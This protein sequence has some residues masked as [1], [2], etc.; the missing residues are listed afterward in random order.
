M[1]DDL[2]YD[3]KRADQVIKLAVNLD[4]IIREAIKPFNGAIQFNLTIVDAIGRSYANEGNMCLLC[5]RD[6]V[7]Q[8]I[9]E[10]NLQHKDD[11]LNVSH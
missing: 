5:A 10:E 6:V 2:E 4:A 7:Q 3:P 11:H 1:S 8:Q 9:Q